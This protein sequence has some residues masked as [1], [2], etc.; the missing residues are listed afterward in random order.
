MVAACLT[1]RGWST[2][3]SGSLSPEFPQT[4]FLVIHLLFVL[5]AF[6][7]ETL[8]S[9]SLFLVF[10][11][12]GLHI[13]VPD[14]KWSSEEEPPCRVMTGMVYCNRGCRPACL[15]RRKPRTGTYGT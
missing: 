8:D 15:Q 5:F 13:A 9:K 12:R 3:T 6:L 4:L 11:N 10:L 1:F 7:L 14:W 2:G